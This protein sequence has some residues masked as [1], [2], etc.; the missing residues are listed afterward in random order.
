MLVLKSFGRSLRVTTGSWVRRSLFGLIAIGVI[1]GGVTA[2]TPGVVITGV[3]TAIVDGTVTAGEWQNAGCR[4]F[5]VNVPEGGT[6]P[7]LVCAMN[8]QANLYF[9]VRFQRSIADPGNTA[10]IEFDNDHDR[11]REDGDDVLVINPSIGFLDAFRTTAPPCP[12]GALCGFL[13]TDFGGTND[14][15]GAFHNDG[16]FTTYEFS[17][18]LDSSD[19]LHDFS[20]R[21]GS[22]VGFTVSVRLIGF[23]GTGQQIADTDFP[24]FLFGD[25]A[26]ATQ[27]TRAKIDIK[28]GSSHNSINRQSHGTIP[29]AILSTLEFDATT[30]VNVASLTFGSTGNEPSLAFCHAADVNGDGLSDL[31]CHF[32]TQAA[33]FRSSD[34]QGILKGITVNGIPFEGADAVR[35]VR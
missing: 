35:I 18:P 22:V 27:V 29:V 28:P 20:I 11:I 14:G 3:G 7:G 21:P 15:A 13:D 4:E 25:V 10:S 24:Q 9:L 17:H 23:V 8:D 31:M 16:V 33:S 1:P 2:Q 34:S 26:I 30:Q 6:T 32:K 12:A 5:L 19:D